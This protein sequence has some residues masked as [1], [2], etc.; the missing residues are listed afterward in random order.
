L[1]AGSGRNLTTVTAKHKGK[2]YRFAYGK[3]YIPGKGAV[4]AEQAAADS[5][6]LDYMLQKKSKVLILIEK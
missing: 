6:V 2:Q 3:F 5:D 4:T 1:K